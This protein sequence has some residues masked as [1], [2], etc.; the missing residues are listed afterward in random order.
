MILKHL[1]PEAHDFFTDFDA[2]IANAA[3]AANALIAIFSNTK[4]VEDQVRLLRDLEHQGDE[5]SHR[6][7][8]SLRQALVPAI[9]HQDIYAL[10][11][12]IDDFVDFIEE[13]GHRYALF[14][15]PHSTAAGLQFATLIRSQAEALVAVIPL[16]RS[17][18]QDDLLRNQLV[19]IHRLENEAD[20]LLSD[21]LQSLYDGV[22]DVDGVV[23][24]KKWGEVYQLLEEATDRAER[25]A[26]TVEG[27]VGQRH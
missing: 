2:A 18:R 22:N 1:F 24:A 13:A 27:I 8:H 5:I 16:L 4:T 6:I 20:E 12:R 25:I 23:L 19:E 3:A 21:V 11:Q 10:T 17:D 7:Y 26:H 14:Q 15:L 9:N